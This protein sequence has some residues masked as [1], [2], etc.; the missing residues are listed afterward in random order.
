MRVFK[1]TK[2]DARAADP[3]KPCPGSHREGRGGFIWRP[4]YCRLTHRGR[5][6]T[7]GTLR[8]VAFV[9]S[10]RIYHFVQPSKSDGLTRYCSLLSAE[11]D[12]GGRDF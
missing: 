10:V 11:N 1:A 7:A 9:K 8:K 6:R 5:A 12:H 2:Y 3:E 4:A